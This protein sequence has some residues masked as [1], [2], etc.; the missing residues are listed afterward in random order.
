MFS[1]EFQS[2]VCLL[3]LVKMINWTLINILSE[4]MLISVRLSALLRSTVLYQ[5][6][7]CFQNINAALDTS[8]SHKW[9]LM[10]V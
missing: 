6:C 7:E 1:G 8:I 2:A 5:K 3:T 9:N 4:M 10:S